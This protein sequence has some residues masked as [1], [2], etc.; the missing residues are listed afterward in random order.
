MRP[1]FSSFCPPFVSVTVISH[2]FGDLRKLYYAQ[3]KVKQLV[4][5]L[6]NSILCFKGLA[7][8]AM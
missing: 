3:N 5:L 6:Y 7:P 4:F 2:G 1:R 8:V